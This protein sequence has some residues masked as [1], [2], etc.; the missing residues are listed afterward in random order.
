MVKFTG[1]AWV[2]G[3]GQ[4]SSVPNEPYVPIDKLMEVHNPIITIDECNKRIHDG[5]FKDIWLTDL[6]ICT[7]DDEN[8]GVCWYDWGAPLFLIKNESY[9]VQIGIFNV[10]PLYF[11]KCGREGNVATYTRVSKY[12]G[13]IHRRISGCGNHHFHNVTQVFVNPIY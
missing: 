13:W 12:L 8:M 6:A 5:G 3:W 2:A 9:M 10:R 1:T 4:Y 11:L 7:R